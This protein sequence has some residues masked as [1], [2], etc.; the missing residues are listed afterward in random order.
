MRITPSLCV[1]ALMLAGGAASAQSA[2]SVAPPTEEQATAAQEF[3]K[4][5]LEPAAEQVWNSV[6]FIIDETGE[7]DLAPK[8]PEDWTAVEAK[9]EALEI[10]VE[11]LREANFV[12]DEATWGGYVDGVI[13]AAEANRLAAIDQDVEAM[14]VA[15]ET[16]DK[17]CESCHMHFEEGETDEAQTPPT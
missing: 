5:T 6:G 9:V 15:G 11:G 2:P 8:T 17:A 3:M 13:E 16:L 1:I 7:H 10:L 12:W 4:T 14:Y